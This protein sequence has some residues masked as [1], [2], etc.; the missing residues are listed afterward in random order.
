MPGSSARGLGTSPGLGERDARAG[1]S[2]G[3]RDADGGE[4]DQHLARGGAVA[5]STRLP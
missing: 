2:G 4:V 3:E 1:G 5:G